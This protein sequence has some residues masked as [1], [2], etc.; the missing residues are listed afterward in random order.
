M[1][2]HV[3]WY[4]A[5]ATGYIA[6]ALVTVSVVTGL[7][8]STALFAGR[9]KPAWTLDLHRFLGGAA[10]TLTGVHLVGLIADNYVHFGAADIL[11]PFASDWRPVA[12]GLGVFAFYLLVAIEVS[13]LLLR[14]LPRRL[15]RGIHLTNGVMFWAASAHL[16]TAGTD[17]G[18]PFSQL[19]VALAIAVVVFLTLVRILSPK[20]RG[21]RRVSATA[22]TPVT[23]ATPT[24]VG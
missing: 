2:P 3:W 10:L 21:R 1:N 12:V 13:S 15:W 7:L 14:H 19:V 23:A 22:A 24:Q 6:W 20:P 8:F 18:H 17:A 5:R 16:V 9:P 11:V 4:L